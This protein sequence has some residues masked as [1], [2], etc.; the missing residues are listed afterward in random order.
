MTARM[1]Q[2]QVF[3]AE[4][5]DSQNEQLG[6]ERLRKRPAVR[7]PILKA[8]RQSQEPAWIQPEANHLPQSLQVSS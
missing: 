6:P 5:E 8:D 7:H 2:R 4:P 3:H 1:K